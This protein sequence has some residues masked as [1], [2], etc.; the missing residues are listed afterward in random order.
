[1]TRTREGARW[2]MIVAPTRRASSLRDTDL[3]V[4]GG[5]RSG[6]GRTLR[7]TALWDGD[8]SIRD[9]KSK[10]FDQLIEDLLRVGVTHGLVSEESTPFDQPGWRLN[11]ACVVFQLGSPSTDGSDSKQNAFFRDLYGNLAT[12]LRAP[13]HPL[14]GFEARE[15]TAQVDSDNREIRE[16]R[17]RF[18]ERERE[19]LGTNEQL[20]REVGETNRFLP[21]LFCSRQ[22][23]SASTSRRSTPSTCA[24]CP[25]RRRTTPNAAAAR[26]AT[27]RL[28]W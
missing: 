4:R 20:L 10:E 25:L 13:T 11:D 1:M 7:A 2:L 26:A 24:T 21:V 14:F 23:S 5:S 12:M 19:D 3:I 15:H 22:W 18:G 27:G 9:L 17:F 28:P 8:M 6:L 16:K